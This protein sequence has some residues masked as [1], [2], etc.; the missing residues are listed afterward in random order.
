MEQIRKDVFETNSSSTHS[1]VILNDYKYKECLKVA[2]PY[3]AKQFEAAFGED[4]EYTKDEVFR[5]FS[6]LGAKVNQELGE[7][8]LTSVEEKEYD[9]GYTGPTAYVD[10]A[11]K[12]M[13]VLTMLDTDGWGYD[14]DDYYQNKFKDLL[15]I[16]GI[17]KIIRPRNGWTGIDHQSKDEIEYQIKYDIQN[18]ILRKDYVLFL[19]HD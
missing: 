3:L 14:Y 9:F 13:F 16:L 5:S 17:K 10:P 4:N 18:F 1:L 12:L 7:I 8:D 15:C 19:D 11:H 2:N 6:S